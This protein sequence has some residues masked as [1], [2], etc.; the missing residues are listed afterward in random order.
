MYFLFHSGSS[1]DIIV[2]IHGLEKVLVSSIELAVLNKDDL[3]T[4]GKRVLKRHGKQ[5]NRFISKLK[6]P[7]SDFKLVLKGKTTNNKLFHRLSPTI[8]PNHLLLDLFAAPRGF[9]VSHT[10]STPVIFFLHNYLP[11]RERFRIEVHP[12]ESIV[13][14]LGHATGVPGRAS[15]FI[16]RFKAAK[17]GRKGQLQNC[18]V[19]VI[20]KNKE[21]RAS[22]HLDLLIQ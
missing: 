12:K 16:V 15:L 13:G 4:L 20:G 1:G 2:T 18:V 10:T 17:S 3:S 14:R 9:V 19:T 5:R 7:Q 8:K 6:V 21:L 22:K 11:H